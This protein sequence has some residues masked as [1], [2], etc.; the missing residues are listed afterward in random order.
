MLHMDE[1]WGHNAKWN[2]PVTRGQTLYDSTY[3]R[4][5]IQFIET[6]NR[7]VLARDWREKGMVNYC[8]IGTEFLFFKMK[9][10]LELNHR[11]GH[12]TI[13]MDSMPLKCSLKNGYDSKFYVMHIL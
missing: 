12:T 11:D 13:W 8:L 7:M 3:M 10:V 2:K 4:Q 5:L 1:P 6:K 9:R